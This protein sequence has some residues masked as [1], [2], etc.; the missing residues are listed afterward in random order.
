MLYDQSGTRKYITVLE[1]SAFFEAAQQR[2]PTIETFCCTLAYSGARLSEILAL[3][4]SGVDLSASAIVVRCLKRRA[5]NVF[6]PIP[7]PVEFLE[8]LEQ[9]HEIAT[10]HSDPWRKDKR[11]W[12]WGRTTAWTRIKEVMAEANIAGSFAMP[13][14]LRHAFCVHGTVEAG[15]PLGIMQGWMGHTRIETTARYGNAVDKEQRILVDR[16][17]PQIEEIA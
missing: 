15:V 1:R 13:K 5:L 11:L 17:W 3:T 12:P 8:R 6:R 4:P 7:V 9:V 10:A 16:M 14:A 2:E